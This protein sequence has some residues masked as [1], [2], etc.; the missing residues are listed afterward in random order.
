[1]KG[2]AKIVYN[3]L[4]F[5]KIKLEKSIEY[6]AYIMHTYTLIILL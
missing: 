2:Y 5:L 4:H 1:M 3:I 6:I